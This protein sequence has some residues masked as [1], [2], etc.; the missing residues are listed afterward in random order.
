MG[1]LTGLFASDARHAEYRAAAFQ[2]TL[3]EIAEVRLAG[4][5]DF[6]PSRESLGLPELV[7]IDSAALDF[8][9]QEWVRE[10]PPLDF[11][12]GF[13][14]RGIAETE[15]TL[16][17]RF[18]IAI[19]FQGILCGMAAGKPSKGNDNLT[20]RFIERYWGENPL[21]GSIAP[22]VVDAA[23]KY[24]RLL[25]KK[26]LKLKDPYPGAIPIYERLGF[27]VA[28]PIGQAIYYAR[29]VEDGARIAQ[30]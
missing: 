16:P 19:W 13:N 17:D 8:W 30:R 27:R 29:E 4:R 25:Q 2:A 11:G 23:D 20:I 18:E 26:R 10:P 28:E 6:D 22:I 15:K 12:G 9:E 7:D 21:T 24:A 3:D 14:W 5:Q 1:D